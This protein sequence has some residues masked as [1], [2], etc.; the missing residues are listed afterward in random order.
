MEHFFTLLIYQPF[1]NILVGIYWFLGLF[2]RGGADMGVAVI[3]FTLVI[4]VLL[5][6]LTLSGE[7]S[8]KERHEIGEKIKELEAQYAAQPIM[9]QREIKKILNKNHRIVFSEITTLVI[10]III[11]LML[12]RIFAKGLPGEDLHLIYS[13]MPKIHQPFNLVFLGKFDLTHPH[14]VLNLIQSAL[15]AILETLYIFSSPYKISRSDVVRLE[16]TLP[17]VSFAVFMFLPAGKKL[18]VITTLCFSI[19]FKLMRMAQRLLKRLGREEHMVAPAAPT[20]TEQTPSSPQIPHN[21]E[22]V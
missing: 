17:V 1:L 5:L 16:L 3:I 13:W 8:E 2:P 14:V 9:L 6:P 12:W 20:P 18:F 4:R 21:R 7:R 10:Q 15:I 22:I 19:G 11:A